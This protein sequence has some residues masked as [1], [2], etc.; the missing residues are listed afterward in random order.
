VDPTGGVLAFGS[1]AEEELVSAEIEVERSRYEKR[2]TERSHALEDRNAEAYETLWS[3]SR[4][5]DCQG[6][7]D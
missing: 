3:E 6:L 7:T 2:L 1:A 5:V 4:R